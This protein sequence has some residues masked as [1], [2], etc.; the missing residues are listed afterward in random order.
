MKRTDRQL[1]VIVPVYNVRPYLPVLLDAL[2]SNF[3]ANCECIFVD[4]CSSDGSVEFIESAIGA[5]SDVENIRLVRHKKNRGL[6]AARNTGVSEAV[7]DY[8]WFIDSD[9]APMS[10][11][12]ELIL[13]VLSVQNIDIV[14]FDYTRMWQSSVAKPL[15]NKIVV[16][17]LAGIAHDFEAGHAPMRLPANSITSDRS[18]I[19]R[20][21]FTDTRFY[22]WCHVVRSSLCR[23][24]PFPEGK[25]F[26]DISVVPMWLM[27]AEG[28]YYLPEVL[29]GYRQRP[30]SILSSHS[31]AKCLDLAGSFCHIVRAYTETMSDGASE[32]F[33]YLCA[34]WITTIYWAA[35]DLLANGSF[36]EPGV[37]AAIEDEVQRFRVVAGKRTRRIVRLIKEDGRK[38]E[39]RSIGILVHGVALFA[40]LFRI[41]R[42]RGGRVLAAVLAR[43]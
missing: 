2:L 1:S 27:S 22:A 24:F 28:V 31:V 30:G 42:S 21:M 25:Y 38:R 43:S 32:E 20:S 37:R 8:I 10:N 3:P 33:D 36:H 39:A 15:D 19:V 4:D 35:R 18:T 6:A 40:F 5:L 41:R 14:V 12:L 11:A 9:D 23:R 17:N 29:I 13:G 7:G 26:E 16:R 34:T